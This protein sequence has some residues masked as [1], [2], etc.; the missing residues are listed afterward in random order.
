MHIPPDR[1]LRE[2]GHIRDQTEKLL[3][4]S[5]MARAGKLNATNL[6]ANHC[7][8]VP[9]DSAPDEAEYLLHTLTGPNWYEAHFSLVSNYFTGD[10]KPSVSHQ[11][12]AD[13]ARSFGD[14][15]MVVLNRD[16]GFDVPWWRTAAEK[17]LAKR[18]WQEAG[19]KL[20]ER[21]TRGRWEIVKGSEHFIHDSHPDVV[22][23]AVAEVVY[24]V[25]YK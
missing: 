16:T 10:E 1:W 18:Q 2:Q 14:L 6:Q 17:Q 11:Q 13:V 12:E 25:R 9:P 5:A 22:V 4:C 19:R 24:A 21:S 15:P 3:K 8:R 20:A 23:N 7:M